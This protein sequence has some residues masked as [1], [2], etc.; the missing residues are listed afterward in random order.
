MKIDLYRFTGSFKAEDPGKIELEPKEFSWFRETE[1]GS[2]PAVY[3]LETTDLEHL[4][5]TVGPLIEHLGKKDSRYDL[6]KYFLKATVPVALAGYGSDGTLKNG[7]FKFLQRAK[8]ARLKNIFFIGTPEKV[9][10]KLEQSAHVAPSSPLSLTRQLQRK[11]KA[12]KKQGLIAAAITGE[13]PQM[14]LVQSLV[15][16]AAE[17]ED[18]HKNPV[19][20]LGETGTGKGLVARQIHEARHGIN[21]PQMITVNCAAIPSELMEAELFGT[22]KG[23]ATNI[24]FRIGKWEAAARGTLFL[25]EIGD[26]SLNHQAK[27][28]NALQDQKICRVG[29]NNPIKVKTEIITATNRDLPRMVEAGTF[30][31]DLY[32]RIC[33]FMI[34]TP[35]LRDIIDDLDTLVD[36]FWGEDPRLPDQI[37]SAFREYN[38][39]GNVRELKTVLQGLSSYFEKNDLTMNHLR[40]Y[41]DY[42]GRSGPFGSKAAQFGDVGPGTIEVLRHLHEPVKCCGR[43]GPPCDP[44]QASDGA[45]R[46]SRRSTRPSASR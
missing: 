2:L 1:E 3:V 8:A 20:L 9:I 45:N 19:L 46:I 14:R 11:I 16:I 41:W 40:T 30:R 29:S 39:P 7:V 34:R 44:K 21:G 37:M 38:W 31:E 25:D 5:T 33:K 13:S 35:P 17:R 27:I 28:L 6:A 23:A 43:S 10:Q 18:P 4:L 36:R 15:A 12:G 42:S 32:F 22:E 26:L 24:G